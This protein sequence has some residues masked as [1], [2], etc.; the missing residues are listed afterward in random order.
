MFQ[1]IHA[2]PHDVLSYGHVLPRRPVNRTMS[3]KTCGGVV[4]DRDVPLFAHLRSTQGLPLGDGRWWPGRHAHRDL[5]LAMAEVAEVGATVTVGRHALATSE[6]S[7]TTRVTGSPSVE[8]LE[9]TLAAL[10][11]WD[12]SV[13]DDPAR[14]VGRHELALSSP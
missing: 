9:R 10:R 4:P 14:S 5:D 11:S 8:L 6:V 13:G 3:R 2:L 12:S 7:P 1:Q